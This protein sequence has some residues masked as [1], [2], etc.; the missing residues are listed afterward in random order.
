[1]LCFAGVVENGSLYT[2]SVKLKWQTV[3]F[4]FVTAHSLAEAHLRMSPPRGYFTVGVPK[5]CEG[6]VA[7][8]LRAREEFA[9]NHFQFLVTSRPWDSK[10]AKFIPCPAKCL[11]WQ[12][13]QCLNV[14]IN[15]LQPTN[16]TYVK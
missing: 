13:R 10:S 5:C 2:F 16:H 1:M 12:I 4:W 11:S 3:V 8:W 6:F 9:N 15:N 14:S 7:I